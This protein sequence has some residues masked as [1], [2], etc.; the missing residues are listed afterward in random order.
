MFLASLH[1][2][3]NICTSLNECL[4]T[5]REALHWVGQF[6]M[7]RK[8]GVNVEF[9]G[10]R[11][12][13]G[14][15]ESMSPSRLSSCTM[16]SLWQL[17]LRVCCRLKPKEGLCC[18]HPVQRNISLMGICFCPWLSHDTS[19]NRFGLCCLN[20]GL[21]LSDLWTDQEDVSPFHNKDRAKVGDNLLLFALGSL[22]TETLLQ[23][24]ARSGPVE[25]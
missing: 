6:V 24:W 10:L 16:S 14:L 22:T 18:C 21:Q 11:Y 2:P 20:Q 5:L 9:L 15:R 3:I 7:E 13:G 17:P 25:L 12:A 8:H 19:T 4:L 1:F 23:R